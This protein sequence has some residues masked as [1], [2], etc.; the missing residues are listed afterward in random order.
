MYSCP[1]CSYSVQTKICFDEHYA[2]VHEGTIIARC[3]ICEKAFGSKSNIW[4]HIQAV[5]ETQSFPC[6]ECDYI[7][8]TKQSLSRHTGLHHKDKIFA[9]EFCDFRAGYQFTVNRHTRTKH[10][11]EMSQNSWLKEKMRKCNFPGCDFESTNGKV[12]RHVILNH[13]KELQCKFCSFKSFV[14]NEITKHVIK[15]HSDSLNVCNLCDYSNTD[16]GK[17]KYHEK[18]KHGDKFFKCDR[19]NYKSGYENNLHWHKKRVHH[20]QMIFECNQCDNYKGKIA[21]FTLHLRTR[22][23]EK[24]EGK[25]SVNNEKCKSCDT[26][27]N[28]KTNFQIHLYWIHSKT[29]LPDPSLDTPSDTRKKSRASRSKTKTDKKKEIAVTTDIKKEDD[30]N[31]TRCENVNNAGGL[32]PMDAKEYFE[33]EENPCKTEEDIS[34]DEEDRDDDTVIEDT[35]SDTEEEQIPHDCYLCPISSCTFS[36]AQDDLILRIRHLETFYPSMDTK[37]S[38]MK[39]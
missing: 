36:M 16:K 4:H 30:E 23:N 15:H 31:S 11:K 25:F 24:Q 19:C 12:N 18:D 28:T 9:C 14:K 22:H 37:L 7:G 8:K 27:P 6:S 32:E 20:E 26:I 13:E 17:L 29:D 10:S 34:D 1:K 21:A 5:H 35:I 33:E 38:F 2:R 39:L 3:P